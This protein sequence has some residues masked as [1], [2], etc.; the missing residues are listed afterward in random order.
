MKYETASVTHI[1]H[2]RAVNQDR[3]LVCAGRK[4]S[5]NAALLVI[6]DGMGGLSDGEKASGAA[7]DALMSWWDAFE[8][9][10]MK[11][12]SEQLDAAIYDVHRQIY[13]QASEKGRRCGST[14]SLVYLQDEQCLLKQIGDSRVYLVDETGLTQLT[15]DQNW[16]NQVTASGQLPPEEAALNHRKGALVNALGASDEL[17]I[18]TKCLPARR[19]T[20]YLLCSDGFYHM[21]PLQEIAGR[22]RRQ[23]P[24]KI[25]DRLLA[26]V[27]EGPASDNASAVLCRLA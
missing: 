6:A 11:S 15:V 5:Y 12:V 7:V 24:Q 14:L 17:N 23:A 22:L 26:A 19:S 18:E 1:G 13:Y 4:G 25:L 20:A 21:A 3:T 27:L 8:G 2:V 9:A 10:E 16:Y